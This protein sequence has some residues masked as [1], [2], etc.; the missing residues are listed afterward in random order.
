MNKINFLIYLRTNGLWFLA[1]AALPFAL[2]RCKIGM[3]ATV[4]FM[5]EWLAPGMEPK[6]FNRCK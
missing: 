1:N 2:S 3:L 4:R 5:I 6:A